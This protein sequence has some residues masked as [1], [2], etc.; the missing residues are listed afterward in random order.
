MEL[1]ELEMFDKTE[2]LKIE[3]FWH[4]NCTYAKLSYLK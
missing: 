4:F 1:Y 2:L 3:L